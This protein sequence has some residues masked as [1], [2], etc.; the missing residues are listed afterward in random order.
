[1][2]PL[3]PGVRGTQGDRSATMLPTLKTDD[4]TVSPDPRTSRAI[5][6]PQKRNESRSV[7][8]DQEV[9]QE[10]C[11]NSNIL[12]K[13]GELQKLLNIDGVTELSLKYYSY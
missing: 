13:Y 6:Q 4:G 12:P 7:R 9:I 1:M 3:D 10:S 5:N 11:H 8:Q 2:S